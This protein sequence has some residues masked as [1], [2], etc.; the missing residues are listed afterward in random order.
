MAVG[1]PS[2]LRAWAADAD[3]DRVIVGEPGLQL[4][5]RDVGFLR[6]LGAQPLVIGPRL[7]K[8]SAVR[9]TMGGLFQKARLRPLPSLRIKASPNNKRIAVRGRA[10]G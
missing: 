3:L 4:D 10:A 1:G 2:R 6:H 9:A 8:G 7:A 5:E